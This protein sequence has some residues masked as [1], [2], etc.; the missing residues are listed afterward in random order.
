MI[1]KKAIKKILVLLNTGKRYVRDD[2]N[3]KKYNGQVL[4]VLKLKAN[5][6]KLWLLELTAQTSNC[7]LSSDII[8][9]EVTRA[10]YLLG[11]FSSS[12][13]YDK[14]II[15]EMF[16]LRDCFCDLVSLAIT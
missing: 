14:T 5:Q 15:N 2:A 12:I 7:V 13:I 16:T 11:G 8:M 4:L 9:G 6:Y 10:Y 1:N 3:Q